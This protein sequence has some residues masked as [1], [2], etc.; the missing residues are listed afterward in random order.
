VSK[1]L[2]VLLGESELREIQRSA[3]RRRMSVSEWVRQALRAARR[4]ERRSDP[5]KKLQVVRAAAEH[6]FPT[7]DIDKMLREIERSYLDSTSR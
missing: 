6:N 3:R 5:G 7:A 4:S 1:K 2:Q